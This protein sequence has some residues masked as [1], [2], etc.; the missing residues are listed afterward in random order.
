MANLFFLLGLVVALTVHEFFHALAAD[1]LG[2]PTP[3]SK[4]R[5]T[6]NP[7]VHLDPIG[8]IMLFFAHFG[9]GKPVPIDPYNFSH[10]RRD[11]LIVSLA[12]PAS[13]LLLAILTA[14]IINLAP[15]NSFIF[16]SLGNF[17][18]INIALGIFNLIPIPP[19]DGS[20]IL[21]NL[22][23]V[24]QSSQWEEALNSYGPFLLVILLFFPV[25]GS[26]ILSTILLPITNFILRLLLPGV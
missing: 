19:L 25:G 2:D 3:R 21:I 15:Q 1:R 9:W 16:S 11:E 23:P 10:P 24:D 5:L 20:R 26:T 4:G 6:L 13:N 22:L 7:L 17:I 8:T 12:G 14:L 18:Y